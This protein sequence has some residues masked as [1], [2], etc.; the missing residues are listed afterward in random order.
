VPLLRRRAPNWEAMTDEELAGEAQRGQREAFGVLYDRYLGG[1]YGYCYRL[2]GDREAAEDANS[3]VFTKALSALPAFH[4]RSFRSWLFAI[5]H[6]VVVDELRGRRATLPLDA[7][8]DMFDPDPSP[9]DLAIAAAERQALRTLLPCLSADQQHVVAL[10]IS[11]LTAAEIAEAMA[12]P[13]NAI[14]GIQHRAV[15]RLR[16]LMSVGTATVMTKGGGDG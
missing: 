2:L 5:A 7:A 15:M 3:A 1:V 10:R 6:N 13:R 16:E 4:A 11:G 8:G 9:E 12:R 14:D